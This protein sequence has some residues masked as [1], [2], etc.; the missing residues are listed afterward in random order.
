MLF[1]IIKQF[2]SHGRLGGGV[3]GVEMALWDLAGKA[4]GIPVWQML[5]GRYR[6]K[7]RLYAYV[8]NSGEGALAKLDLGQFKADV[9]HRM[10]EQGFTWLKMHPGIEVY[11][12]IP[13]TTVN[14]AFVPGF[15]TDDLSYNSYQST[16]HHATAIQVTDKGLAEL[17]KYVET[18]RNIVGYEVPLSADHMGHFDLNNCIRVARAMEPYRLASL[19]DFLP[20]E[21]A[22]G[23]KM[24][25]DAITTP[26]MTGEDMF[27]TA[28][29]KKLC[30]MR[31]VDIV[32][33]DLATA[34]GILETKKIGDYA[35]ENG[36]AMGLHFAGTPV[37]FMANVHSA[38]AT[39]N[40]LALEVPNQIVDNPWWSKLVNMVGSQPIYEK[41][42]A[43]VPL[44]APGLGC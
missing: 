19:E 43:H 17:A 3:S 24:I 28:A 38:A 6:D 12:S 30:D 10:D 13:G 34:G 32:Q 29:F 2:G 11:S 37:C 31:A 16:K 18:I 41:G 21:D 40:V 20:W 9:K 23:L 44:D 26:T 8:P 33:P 42:F 22:E 1:K 39:Q 5:G 36:I 7:V 4:Y 14:T 35:E 15:G 27:G 25:T